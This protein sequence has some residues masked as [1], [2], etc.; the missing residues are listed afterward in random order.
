[1][2]DETINWKDC[3]FNETLKFSEQ[4]R[5]TPIPGQYSSLYSELIEKCNPK[6]YISPYNPDLL[7]IAN[8]I[9]AHVLLQKEIKDE[10]TLRNLR[11]LAIRDLE[12]VFSTEQLYNKLCTKLNPKNYMYDYY[13]EKLVEISNELYNKV[14]MNADNIIA[15]ESIEEQFNKSPLSSFLARLK[16]EKETAYAKAERL[17]KK[18]MLVVFMTLFI[19]MVMSLIAYHLN[20]LS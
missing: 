16:E 18:V 4:N 3:A 14:L 17:E 6:N 20:K 10:K 11:N 1:M 9:Y 13:D 5:R 15:L 2:S 12:I 8:K 7:K 19:I